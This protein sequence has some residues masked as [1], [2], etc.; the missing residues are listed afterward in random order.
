MPDLG[1]ADQIAAIGRVI[2]R[3]P[4]G[5][6]NRPYYA[7]P[8]PLIG[9]WATQLHDEFGVRVHAELAKKDLVRVKTGAGNFGPV[10]EVVA[11]G[12]ATPPAG[13]P[14][15]DVA[16]MRGARADL[17]EWM[18]AQGPELAGLADRVVGAEGDAERTALVLA[19]IRRD[20]P[21]V[22][23]MGQDMVN[24]TPSERLE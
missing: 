24:R 9:Y 8:P 22:L 6:D 17:L 10:E 14:D 3:I 23:S 13:G 11:T 4:T 16:R 21:E 1:R 15:D 20:H 18:R 12:N 5:N 2:S 19:E 7:T